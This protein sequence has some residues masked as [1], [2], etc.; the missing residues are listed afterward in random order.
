[1]EVTLENGPKALNTYTRVNYTFSKGLEASQQL[2]GG[3]ESNRLILANAIEAGTHL[4]ELYGGHSRKWPERGS[5]MGQSTY[6]MQCL[7]CYKCHG[8]HCNN[9][10]QHNSSN[11]V[12]FSLLL[13]RPVKA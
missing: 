12:E 1:M 13:N 3:S 2:V 4:L 5:P 9:G 8:E 10:S 6:C 11:C 7:V